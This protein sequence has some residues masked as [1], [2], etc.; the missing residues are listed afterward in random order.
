MQRSASLDHPE[1][2]EIAS[3]DFGF[4]TVSEMAQT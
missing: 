2:M 1:S 3:P 4:K